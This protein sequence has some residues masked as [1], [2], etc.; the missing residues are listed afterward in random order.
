MATKEEMLKGLYPE[1]LFGY[2][3]ELT[4]GEVKVLQKLREELEKRVRLVLIDCYEM[5]QLPR[6]EIL[7]IFN[8]ALR[9]TTTRE[10]FMKMLNMCN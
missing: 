7:G 4:E 10:Q 5:A 9:L 8:A 2:A 6:E 1:D 3:N